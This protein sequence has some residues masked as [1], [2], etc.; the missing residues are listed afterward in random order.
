MLDEPDQTAV[1]RG[2]RDGQRDAWATLYQ[3]YSADIWRYVA[4][5]VGAS[6]ADVADV[7]QETFL[8][9]ARSAVRFDPDRG[10]LWSWLTGIAHHQTSLYWRQSARQSR[11][12]T[13]AEQGA[14]ELR[15]LLD[16]SGDDSD[17][18]ERRE[19]ADLVR[20]TLASLSGDYAT[21]LA[22]KYLDDFSLEQISRQSGGSVDATKSRLA[23][24]RREFK[25]KF[26]QMSRDP[27]PALDGI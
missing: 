26:E 8:A 10:T 6:S 16:E 13:L 5:L 9:A 27:I 21:I 14:G 1:I 4:R 18:W 24:A 17:I 20:A 7:V 22:A 23:R 3:A 15:R 25:L 19:M 12:R 11:L 2:L